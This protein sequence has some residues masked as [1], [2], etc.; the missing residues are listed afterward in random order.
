MSDKLPTP[1]KAWIEWAEQGPLEWKYFVEAL[2]EDGAMIER[3]SEAFFADWRANEI[4]DTHDYQRAIGVAL[5][6][7]L[8]VTD[9]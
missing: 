6:A 2:L 4:T 5:R 9:E 7:A 3:A 8:E 1:P